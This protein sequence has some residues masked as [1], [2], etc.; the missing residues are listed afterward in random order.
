MDMLDLQMK[1]RFLW[2]ALR[3]RFRDQRCELRALR[4]ALKQ[5][6]TAIDV[7]ANKGSY[8]FWLSRWTTPGRVVAFEPQL[9]LA[10]YLQQACAAL[11]LTNVKIEAAAVS[12]ACGSATLHIPGAGDSPG[13]SL[14]QR[15]SERESCRNTTVPVFNIDDYFKGDVRIGAIKVDVEG[16]ELSVFQGAE[17]I[18][19][20][21]GPVLVFECENRHLETGSVKDIFDYLAKMNYQGH[22]IRKNKLFPISEFNAK[23]HQRETGER[24]WDAQDYCNNFVFRK[25]AY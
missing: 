15:I 7:G 2:R 24:F 10:R 14:S 23:I 1:T 11:L 21:Q 13:A 20:E 8:L 6:D 18:L 25:K 16:Y 4:L 17:R 9:S 12:R 5:G 3:A 22:F 19:R